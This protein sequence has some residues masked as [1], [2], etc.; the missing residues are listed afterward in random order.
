MSILFRNSNGKLEKELAA[1]DYRAHPVRNR[2]AVLAVTLTA[3]L[4]VVIFTVGIGFMQAMSRSMG[5]SPGPG[6]DSAMIFGDKE[7]LARAKALP[8]VDWA[9][10]ARRCSTSYLHNREFSGLD[11]RLFAAD[12]VH[13]EKNMVDLVKGRYPE[14]A[15]EI[16]LSDTMSERLGLG[17]ELD[18]S[19]DLVVLVQGEAEGEQVER[20]IPM[21]VCG[22]YKNPLRGVSDI[23]EEIYTG[24]DFI[25]AYNPGLPKGYDHIYVKLNNYN[26]LKLGADKEEKLIEV[27]EQ[28]GGNGRQYKSSD[29]TYAALAPVVLLLLCVMLCGYFFIYNVFDISIEN[30]IR[31]YGELKTIGMTRRQLRR[32]LLWQMNR[33]ALIGILL[34]GTSG[35]GIGRMAAGSVMESFADGIASFY[36]P[37][38]FGQVFVLG[39]VFSWITVFISTMKPFRIAS[40]ISPVE[41][42]RY[43]GRKKKGV[44]S[45]ISFALSGILFLVVYTVSMGYSV[46]VQTA[47]HNGTDFRIGQKAALYGAE[48]PYQPVSQDLVQQIKDLEFVEDFRIFYIARTQPDWIVD[49]G[50]Y[51]YKTSSG[52]IAAQGELASDRQAYVESM[53]QKWGGDPW[54]IL[55]GK[56]ERGNYPVTISGMDADY[57]DHESQYFTLLEGE[58]N[59]EQF[60]RGNYLIYNRSYYTNDMEQSEGMAN[61][62]HAGDQVTVSFYDSA[63]ERYVER[64]FT[65]MALVNCHDIYGTGNLESI[66]IWLTD[67]V[68]REIYTNYDDLVGSIC[69]NASGKGKDGTVLSER[70][71]YEAVA[72]LVEKDGNLQLSLEAAYL[73]RVG[74]METKRAMTAFGILLSVIVGLI[75]VANMVNTVTTDVMA[76]KVEYAAMQSIGM[77]GRQMKRDIFEKYAGLVIVA[78]GLATAVGAVLAYT[79]GERPGFNFSVGAFVQAFA[80]FVGIS[81]G[82]C[83]VMSQVLTWE[84]NRKSIVERL[85]EVV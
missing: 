5:A 31:F 50:G 61:Q 70:E 10:Y 38:G 34:G 58:L 1:D 21:T 75:G 47:A 51:F 55:P 6:A 84:M 30:D 16:L 64:E 60:A 68:F 76:R 4:I 73:S 65:V 45:V 40:T 78:L 18:V 11:V 20:V 24:E 42:A 57:L 77:T 12:E 19:Y 28:A 53:E 85:R 9:A 48:E 13:Y 35:Y 26:P 59:A 81:A 29:M 44:F 82:L 23:Y 7:I 25:A 80:I 72:E 36:K 71:Q 27:N 2:L 49:K 39:A 62:V 63:A 15:D 52:E 69:F 3:V 83:V 46:E 79:V 17:E 22:Y 8:Q 66:N 74:N 14:S 41:A 32:M 56:N 54:H 37:A 43:R 67:G 33:I